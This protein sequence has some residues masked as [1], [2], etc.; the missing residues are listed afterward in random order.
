M[1]NI[2]YTGKLF[3]MTF[4]PGEAN[5]SF[6]FHFPLHRVWTHLYTKFKTF[7]ILFL[8]TIVFKI[9]IKCYYIYMYVQIFPPWI[10]C[11]IT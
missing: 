6:S 11:G 5:M 2:W 9:I 4:F 7:I 3:E 1:K 10:F 8:E